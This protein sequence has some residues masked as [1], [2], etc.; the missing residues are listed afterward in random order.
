[1]ALVATLAPVQE[2]TAIVF[3]HV[4]IVHSSINGPAFESGPLKIYK[5]LVESVFRDTDGSLKTHY[6]KVAYD[7]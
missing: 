4:V 1:M 3:D 2:M 7:Q 6:D 5:I